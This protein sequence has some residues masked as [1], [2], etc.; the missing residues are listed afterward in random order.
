VKASKTEQEPQWQKTP[1]AK[2]RPQR[3]AEPL[4]WQ[5]AGERQAD[6]EIVENRP[7]ELGEDAAGGLLER[8][9]AEGKR[10]Q[11]VARGKMTFGDVLQTYRERLNGDHSLK[12]RSKTY[13]EERIA[14]LLKSWPELSETDIARISK[15]DC[16]AWAARF[17]EKAAPSLTSTTRWEHFSTFLGRSADA[18]CRAPLRQL[19]PNQV[20][21]GRHQPGCKARGIIRFTHPAHET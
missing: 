11:A 9:T 7:D 13:R 3:G 4:L 16:L 19:E 1:I 5:T 6:L 8:A 18:N 20:V 2:P 14:A 10:G 12:E 17:G 15:A 21:S